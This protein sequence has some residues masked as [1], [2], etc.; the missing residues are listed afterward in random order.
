LLRTVLNMLNPNPGDGCV[1]PPPKVRQLLPVA[2]QFARR[3]ACAQGI[4]AGGRVM[5]GMTSVVIVE[6]AGAPAKTR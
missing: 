2:G 6:V 5:S 1:S 4:C 3:A